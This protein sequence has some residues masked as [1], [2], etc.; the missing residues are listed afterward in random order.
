M[1]R[2]SE[3]TDTP[4]PTD[5]DPGSPDDTP[6]PAPAGS[7]RA[8]YL[9]N[10]QLYLFALASAAVTANAY[11]IHPIISRVAE[12]FGV[13]DAMIGAV[14]AFNQ[15][16]LALGILLLLPLGDRFSNRRLISIFVAGQFVSLVVMALA[17]GFV[18]FVA[19][20]TLLGFFTI[21]PYLLPAYVSKRVD[22]ARLGHA[23]A[24]LTTGIIAGILLARAGAGVVGEYLGWRDVYYI[25]AAVML[26]VTFLLP[27]VMDERDRDEVPKDQGSYFKLIASL[28]P[29]IRQYPEILLTG[30]IQALSFGIFLSVWMGLGLYLTSPEMGYGVDVVG[31]LAIL[32]IVNLLSTTPLGKW[33]DRVGPRRARLAMASFQLAGVGLL[34]VFGHSLWLLIIPLT[35]MNICGP[36]VDVTNRMTFLSKAADV[37]TRLMTVYI[38]M[39]FTGGGIA[40]WAGTAAY[41][42]AGWTGNAVLAMSLSALVFALALWSARRDAQKARRA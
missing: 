25:A 41:D 36:V 16:A 33:A 3:T 15:I 23:T 37:R 24:L 9:S 42:F 7:G 12:D 8:R 18:L 38:V 35:I 2:T 13:S 5:T 10:P 40:S 6:E 1:A 27:L 29:L 17:Q 21:A 32:A 11:Y 22:S 34:L 4:I 31:Y 19:G 14:P 28:G 30:A 39:M 20:S 26:A